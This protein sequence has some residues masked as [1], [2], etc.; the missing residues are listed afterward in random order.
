MTN[1]NPSFWTRAE[2]LR[3]AE[4]KQASRCD[5]CGL[6]TRHFVVRYWSGEKAIICWDWR[7]DCGV[8]FPEEGGTDCRHQLDI[9][10]YCREAIVHDGEQY[11]YEHD[12][13]YWYEVNESVVA[14]RI[15]FHE[16]EV[17]A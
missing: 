15:H 11:E 16:D 8:L 7:E 6:R 10:G 9:A 14:I 2:Q 12:G 1:P 13:G 5:N 3:R 4:D 17:Q